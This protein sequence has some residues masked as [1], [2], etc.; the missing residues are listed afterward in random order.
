MAVEERRLSNNGDRWN[1]S[2]NDRQVASAFQNG[3]APFGELNQPVLQ[4]RA[5]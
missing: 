1:Q 3:V 2:R 5:Y 4:P